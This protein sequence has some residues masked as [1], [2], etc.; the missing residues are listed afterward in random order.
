MILSR[1]VQNH[2][3]L[4]IKGD[5]NQQ[6]YGMR[7]Y[8]PRVGRFLSVDPIAREYPE[9][10]TY[11]FAS[12]TPIMAIDLDGLEMS[13]KTETREIRLTVV[14]K[15]SSKSLGNE[16]DHGSEFMKD[17]KQQLTKDFEQT[18]SGNDATGNAWIAKVDDI[19]V[20]YDMK[21]EDANEVSTLSEKTIVINLID[22][23]IAYNKDG[24]ATYAGGEAERNTPSNGGVNVVYAE[25]TIDNFGY[26]VFR[27]LSL[28]NISNNIVHELG[29][30]G[31]LGHPWEIEEK[32]EPIA[33]DMRHGKPYNSKTD[34][35][36]KEIKSNSMNSM[37]NPVESLRSTGSKMTPGQR[38]IVIES[39]PEN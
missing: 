10:T 22:R 12:N 5:D 37:A 28:E 3:A 16:P 8:D 18:Y 36:K 34:S 24:T 30:K 13:K 31:N 2:S 39:I 7:I 14:L 27:K 15:N 4:A 9:L 38:Q 19:R 23:K 11:Q 33:P 20:I 1:T 29:H 6:D 21:N 25:K 35:P 17:L 26:E 32:D